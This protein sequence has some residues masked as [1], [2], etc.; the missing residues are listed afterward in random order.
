MD[1]YK[2]VH[3]SQNKHLSTVLIVNFSDYR[4]IY[5]CVSGFGSE[6]RAVT[7]LKLF[8]PE[9]NWNYSTVERSLWGTEHILAENL[10][11]G[12]E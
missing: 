8:I 11:M 10:S 1:S 7:H 2:Y 6:F 3:N 4:R 12:E 9:V 5:K